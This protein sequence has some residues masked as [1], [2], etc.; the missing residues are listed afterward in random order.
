MKTQRYF[1]PVL[2]LALLGVSGAMFVSTPFT[3]IAQT[4]PDFGNTATSVVG[5]P[6]KSVGAQEWQGD[7]FFFDAE[8]GT[9]GEEIPHHQSGGG[10][11]F[12]QP[13]C[14]GLGDRATYQSSGNVPQGNQYFQWETVDSQVNHYCE[15]KNVGVFPVTEILGKTLY[16]AFYMRFDRKDGTDIWHEGSGTQ[17]WDKGIEMRGHGVRWTVGWG[18]WDKC[19]GSYSP[20]FAANQDHHFTIGSGNPT[21]HLPG[22]EYN[23][24]LN[25]YSCQNPPQ[26]TYERWYAMI[27]GVNMA[28]DTTGS[29]TLWL[30]G[31]KIA[32]S[33]GIQTTNDCSPDIDHIT[34]GGT[35][36]QGPP[37]NGYDAPSHYRKF[38]ALIL[39]DSWQDIIDG[40]YLSDPEADGELLLHGAPSD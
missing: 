30:N 26:L 33:T 35:I 27:L 12:C 5:T 38:D 11:N 17:S 4:E 7:Y 32:E 10:S 29:R 9:I 2:V 3:T 24:N 1:G 25:G 37:P 13:E 39:T 22:S 28:C 19:N 15:I 20:G 23:P 14:S 36:A 34:M 21:Y 40:G 16:L 8:E 31:V 6:E 18:Q